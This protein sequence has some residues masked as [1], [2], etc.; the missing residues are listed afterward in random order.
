MRRTL[1]V[2]DSRPDSSETHLF[3]DYDHVNSCVCRPILL[4]SSAI[5]QDK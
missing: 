1:D 3:L 2:R 5:D 4:E